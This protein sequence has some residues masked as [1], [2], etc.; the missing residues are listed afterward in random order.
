MKNESKN[1]NIKH[2]LKYIN[3]MIKK[4]KEMVD[5]EKNLMFK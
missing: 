3:I 4:N 5:S 1:K 2:Y